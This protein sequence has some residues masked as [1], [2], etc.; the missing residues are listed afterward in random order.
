MKLLKTVLDAHRFVSEMRREGKSVALVPTMGALHEGHLSLVRAGQQRCDATVATI[1]V[2][3][4]QFAAGEDLDKYPRT[5]GDDL[6]ALEAAGCGGVFVPEVAEMYPPGCT[7]SV[8]PPEIARPL[9]G[10]FRPTHFQG[11][12][13]I[14]LKLFH[15]LPAS[16]AFFGQKDLQQLR[17]IEAMVRDLNL[18]IEIIG[19]PIVRES[20]GLAMSSRNRYLDDVQ[21][22][23][24][25]R[26][27]VALDEAERAIDDGRRD[28]DE[29]QRIMRSALKVDS[30]GEGVDSIDYAV[31]V[32]SQT[33]APVDRFAGEVALLIAA[34]V[35]ATRLIDNRLVRIR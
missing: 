3:P 33:L 29:L 35:G 7:T 21:R 31:A 34:H 20:D 27:S 5:L 10:A 26:L 15:I 9:E 17:V 23:R 32:D 30:P 1:F 12:A 19:C 13:T 18:A 11:V 16:H 28:P 4:T 25:L 2:N 22:R 6:A 14:V 8:N 24:A